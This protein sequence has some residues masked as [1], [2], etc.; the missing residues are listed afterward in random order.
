MK[1]REKTPFVNHYDVL[2]QV[3]D[4]YIYY[5]TILFALNQ[6]CLYHQYT[7][8]IVHCCLNFDFKSSH[9]ILYPVIC[10]YE[11][12]WQICVLGPAELAYTIK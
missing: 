8:C 3:H 4:I 12:V 2:L 7:N 6:C 1:Q 9:Y 10:T 11:S 5:S